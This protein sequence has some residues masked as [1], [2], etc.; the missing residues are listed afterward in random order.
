MTKKAKKDP[1]ERVRKIGER[2]EIIETKL[3]Q[4]E[5]E[6]LRGTVMVL[7]DRKDEILE[8]KSEVVKN[9]GSQLATVDLEIDTTRRLIHSG[10]R[11]IDITVDEFL[12]QGNEIVRIRRD[13]GEQIG[14][15]TATQKEL[16]EPLFEDDA[17]APDPGVA[18]DG[19]EAEGPPDFS[20]DFGE[21]AEANPATE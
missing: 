21:E 3:T 7:L 15:R 16:Q 1:N 14:A 8:K 13:T 20:G 5:I 10:R 9:Y 12:T 18:A 17:E 11:K 19:E 6:D 2:E 4:K